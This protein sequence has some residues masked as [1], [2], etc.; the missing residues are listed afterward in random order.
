MIITNVQGVQSELALGIRVP[1]TVEPSQDFLLNRVKDYDI[2]IKGTD[3]KF[4]MDLCDKLYRYEGTCG[5]AIDTFID[6]SITKIRAEETGK[7]DLDKILMYFNDQV[8]SNV[9]STLRGMQEVLQKVGLDWF[10]RGNAFPYNSWENVDVPEVAAPAK[11]PTR[12]VLLNPSLVNIPKERQ[13]LG[14]AQLFFQPSP[15]MMTLLRQDGRS[16]P[17]L[18]R[19]KDLALFKRNRIDNLYGFRLNPKFVKHIKR[20]GNDYQAWG[21]PYLTKAFSAVA[22]I[23]RL[24]RLDDSTTEGLVNLI[25]I[26]K[27]GDKDFPATPSRL[28]SFRSLIQNPTATHTLVWPH[29][30]GVEQVGPD[31]KLLAFEKK[32]IEPRQELLRALGVPAILIDPSITRG[33]DPWASVI[34]LAERLQKFRDALTV[35]VED[36]YHQIAESNGFENV[37][38]KARWERMNLANDEAIKNLIMQFYDRGLIDAQTALEESNYDYG[39]II[40]RKKRNKKQDEVLMAPPQLPFGGSIQE[41]G[42]PRKDSPQDKSDKKVGTKPAVDQKVQRGPAK[43]KT[44]RIAASENED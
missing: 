25:T 44:K 42:R 16:H 29:D 12:I 20:K 6:F 22:S 34:A 30:V 37:F 26:Y 39:T 38:P 8:N 23:R 32:Y 17:G 19:L 28:N 15:E 41:K 7:K 33:G 2:N 40:T 1:T 35:W 3:I 10:I 43:P 9:T 11:I 5:T 13:M 31:G 36:I 14:E 18:K 27:I 24:R 4:T 21:I